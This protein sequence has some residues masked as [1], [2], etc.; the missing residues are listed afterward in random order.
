MGVT[1]DRLDSWV[2]QA[3][4]CNDIVQSVTMVA[5]SSAGAG[6]TEKPK[7][8]DGDDIA[9]AQTGLDTAEYVDKKI[10]LTQKRSH[11]VLEQKRKVV[12]LHGFTPENG[13]FRSAFSFVTGPTT[14]GRWA[15]GTM[16]FM[17]TK[18]TLDSTDKPV[19]EYEQTQVW[20]H[21]GKWKTIKPT[22]LGQS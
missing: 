22:D 20:E 18:D 5:K 9:D 1:A 16:R 3:I 8:E 15:T 7:D 12:G 19:G 14:S 17:C 10:T 21:F 6:K 2:L 4:A 13:T 11:W